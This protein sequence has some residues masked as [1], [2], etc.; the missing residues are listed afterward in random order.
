M[1]LLRRIPP[2]AVGGGSLVVRSLRLLTPHRGLIRIALIHLRH[3]EDEAL[4]VLRVLPTP[5]EATDNSADDFAG[6]GF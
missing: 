2:R 1:M 5:G 4:L 6:I 3:A